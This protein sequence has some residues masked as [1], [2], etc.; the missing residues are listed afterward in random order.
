[1]PVCLC[2]QEITIKKKK[3]ENEKRMLRWVVKKVG[4]G[5]VKGKSQ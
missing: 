1:M 3:K 4:L 5:G 2:P